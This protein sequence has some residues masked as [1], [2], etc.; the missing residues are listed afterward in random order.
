MNIECRACNHVGPIDE[1]PPCESIYQDIRCPKCG[2]TNNE[3]NS[4][5]QKELFASM[6]ELDEADK[7]A[8]EQRKQQRKQE[9]E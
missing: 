8:D 5:Y 4:K 2:S 3:H 7:S 6:R 1:F 9:G